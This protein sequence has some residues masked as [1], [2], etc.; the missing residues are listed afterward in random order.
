MIIYDAISNDKAI[1]YLQLKLQ[2]LEA[3]K[4]YKR[5]ERA[6]KLLKLFKRRES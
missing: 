1:A 3:T 5:A 2:T 4:Q 6:K